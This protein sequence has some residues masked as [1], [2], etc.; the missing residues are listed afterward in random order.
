MMIDYTTIHMS[1]ITNR[2]YLVKVCET[3][4]VFDAYENIG[5]PGN[6]EYEIKGTGMLQRSDEGTDIIN[7]IDFHGSVKVI[8]GLDE[9]EGGYWIVNE[10]PESNDLNE[11]DLKYGLIVKFDNSEL[12]YEP[13][14]D[15]I[16]GFTLYNKN[17][18]PVSHYAKCNYT[19]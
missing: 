13:F 4:K 14:T 1:A 3:N 10:I 5:Y 19:E 12:W 18:I 8:M 6:S 11:I 16:N 7:L 2:D 9:I 17:G 15:E